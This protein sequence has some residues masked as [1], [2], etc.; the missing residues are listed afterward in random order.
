[1]NTKVSAGASPQNQRSSGGLYSLL[2]S[3]TIDAT[4]FIR[5]YLNGADRRLAAGEAGCVPFDVFVESLGEMASIEE[6]AE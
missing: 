4:P 3:G 1:M 5:A 2:S 6:A